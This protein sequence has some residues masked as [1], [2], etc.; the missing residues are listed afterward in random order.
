MGLRNRKNRRP[1]NLPRTLRKNRPKRA[2]SNSNSSLA[3]EGVA[4]GRMERVSTPKPLSSVS[5]RVNGYG[6]IL[7]LQFILQGDVYCGFLRREIH[8]NMY[9][10][11]M[12]I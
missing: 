12:T 7:S 10:A 9:S 4:V 8:F 3:E 1:K 6:D 5:R 11:R 2:N